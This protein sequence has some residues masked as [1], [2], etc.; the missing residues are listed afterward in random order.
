MKKF[1][2][3]LLGKKIRIYTD[4]K[5]FTCKNFNNN[6][7][8]IWRKI[9]EEYGLDIEYIKCEKD[10]VADAPSIFTLNGNQDTTPKSIYQK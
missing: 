9:L 6:I 3:I 5:N 2:T 1:R 8:L 10:I 4:N 7:L